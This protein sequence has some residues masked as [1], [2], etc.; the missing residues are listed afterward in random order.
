MEILQQKAEFIH[1]NRRT[2]MTKLIVAFHNSANAPESGF[3][4]LLLSVGLPGCTAAM[5]LIVL[6]LMFKLSP[7]VVS[8]RD[9][10]SQRWS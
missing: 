1:A 4:L 8:A 7:P 5:W 3:F 6:P 2:D 10:G 9:P